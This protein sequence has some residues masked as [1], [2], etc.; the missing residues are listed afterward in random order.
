[1][2]ERHRPGALS[3]IVVV[4]VATR[5]L[6][7]VASDAHARIVTPAWRPD[8]QAVVAAV[9]PEDAPFNLHEF[10][11][12]AR[13]ASRQLTR[14]TGGAIWPDVA[15]DGQ[16]IVF[17]G[18]TADGFDLFLTAYAGSC[19]VIRTRD[20]SGLLASATAKG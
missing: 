1:M 10:P 14:T 17:A 20:R 3:E 6:R 15:H 9:A 8:G 19:S 16:S 13:L 4:D 5:A 11:L 12:D 18:Y 2:V 7:V